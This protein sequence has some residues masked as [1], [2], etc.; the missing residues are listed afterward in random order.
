MGRQVQLHMFEDDCKELFAFV[1]KHDPVIVIPCDS[2]SAELRELHD[3]CRETGT[4]CLWNQALLPLVQYRHVPESRRGSYYRI[5]SA[6]PVIEF[7]PGGQ[8]EWND[9]HALLQGRLY[10]PFEVAA[11]EREPFTSW[12]DA[13]IRWIRAHWTKNP[14]P[15]L[16]GY[17]GPRAFQAYKEG[18]TLLPM[19]QPPLTA[20]WLSWT[21]AQDG[22]R[23]S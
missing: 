9:R 17:V 3:P 2:N 18:T 20:E 19:F 7:T 6:L 4:L 13:L 11:R 16:G 22:L 10:S 23:Q 12:F 8:V 15:L 14:V 5:D 21:T 1:R